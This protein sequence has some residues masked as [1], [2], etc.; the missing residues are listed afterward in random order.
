MLDNPVFY[1]L[2]LLGHGTLLLVQRLLDEAE[3]AQQ[4]TLYIR[5]V[6]LNLAI[7]LLRQ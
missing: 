3:T 2:F 1:L 6:V 7:F 4:R 5:M